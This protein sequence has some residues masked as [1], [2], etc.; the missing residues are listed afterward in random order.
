MTER[1]VIIGASAAGSSAAET[2]RRHA[3]KAQITVVSDEKITYS[4]PLLSYYLAGQ[5]G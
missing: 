4:K 2:L 3:P 1:F 5:L